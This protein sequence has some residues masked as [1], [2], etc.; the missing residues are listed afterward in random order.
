MNVTMNA[1]KPPPLWALLD[2][3]ARMTE[4]AKHFQ[5]ENT[6]DRTEAFANLTRAIELNILATKQLAEK[7]LRGKGLLAGNYLNILANQ[8]IYLP[9]LKM[10]EMK[11]IA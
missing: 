1:I 4:R 2:E 8:E 6:V 3:S 9:S 7:V 10:N 5:K 11:R